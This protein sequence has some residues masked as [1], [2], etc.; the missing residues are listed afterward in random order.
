M[1]IDVVSWNGVSKPF[2][3]EGSNLKSNSR[4]YVKH[5]RNDLTPAVKEHYPNDN[6]IFIQDSAP[7]HRAKIIQNFL[8]E[9]LKSRFAAI[10]NGHPLLLI[11]IH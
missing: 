7:S 3:V 10:R 9:K 11:A 2:F 1:V 4:S 6:F 8:R 5:L